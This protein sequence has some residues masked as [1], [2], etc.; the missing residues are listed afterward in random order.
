MRGSLCRRTDTLGNHWNRSYPTFRRWLPFFHS[1]GLACK[2][3]TTS[4]T[5]ASPQPIFFRE[6]ATTR[7]VHSSAQKPYVKPMPINWTRTGDW[8]IARFS[9]AN[10]DDCDEF[11][12]AIQQFIESLPRGS[13]LA[14]SF[15]GVEW[16]SS[17]VIGLIMG[18]SARIAAQGG[19]FAI[20]SPSSKVMEVLRITNLVNS[21]TIKRST[22]DLE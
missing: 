9:D 1:M 15:R 20:T 14:I 5:T 7:S 3:M 12:A 16:I 11:S 8:H 19:K 17:R 10:V 4:S 13:K 6:A 22:Y 18:A 21:L 2:K